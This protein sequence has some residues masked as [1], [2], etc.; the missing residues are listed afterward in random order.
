MIHINIGA[1]VPKKVTLSM[2]KLF[3]FDNAQG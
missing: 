1:K 3:L 2:Q